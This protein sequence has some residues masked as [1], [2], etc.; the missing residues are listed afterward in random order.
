MN[1]AFS[2]PNTVRALLVSFFANTSIRIRL[3]W[4]I[5]PLSIDSEGSPEGNRKKFDLGDHAWQGLAFRARSR[6]V[7]GMMAAYWNRC[8]LRHHIP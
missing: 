7:S 3:A 1:V 8:G 6:H 4:M 2:E 5:A